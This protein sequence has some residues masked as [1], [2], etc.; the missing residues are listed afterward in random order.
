MIDAG[1]FVIAGDWDPTPTPAKRLRIIMPP[2]GTVDGAGWAPYT[3]AGLDALTTRGVKGWRVLDVG[4]GTGIIAVAA[5]KLGA[6]AVLALDI[7]PDALAFAQRVVDLNEVGSVVTV[8]EGSAPHAEERFDLA[9]VSISTETARAL[10]PLINA[11][12][13]LVIHDDYT[14]E[15]VRP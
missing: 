12:R 15:E 14:V 11:T 13:V 7:H 10:L 2:V 6:A 5:A 4:T 9:I 3:R 8:R 1:R